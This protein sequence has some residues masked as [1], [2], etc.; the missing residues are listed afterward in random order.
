MNNNNPYNRPIYPNYPNYPNYTAYPTYP[1]YP[2][3]PTYPSYTAYPDYTAH[4]NVYQPSLPQNNTPREFKK[5]TVSG[6]PNISKEESNTKES[7]IKEPNI[8]EPVIKPR[9]NVNSGSDIYNPHISEEDKEYIIWLRE[10]KKNIKKQKEEKLGLKEDDKEPVINTNGDESIKNEQEPVKEELVNKPFVA[11]EVKFL[12]N[13]EKRHIAS[14]KE[15]HKTYNE[16]FLR[17]A[18][19]EREHGYKEEFYCTKY[20]NMDIEIFLL[21]LKYFDIDYNLRDIKKIYTIRD[22]SLFQDED[23][24]NIINLCTATNK[25]FE[26]NDS[27]LYIQICGKVAPKVLDKFPDYMSKLLDDSVIP[28]YRGPLDS[29]IKH[30]KTIGIDTDIYVEDGCPNWTNISTT[31]GQTAL[32]RPEDKRKNYYD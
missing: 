23:G 15:E 4:Y 2:T 12:T 17:I 22:P 18:K 7:N 16:N 32:K 20:F 31:L 6:I 5:I 13:R 19:E 1:N 29:C 10:S 8:K 27:I 26:V 25:R 28:L 21:L 3:Y 9:R 14:I 11:R 30:L 24:F